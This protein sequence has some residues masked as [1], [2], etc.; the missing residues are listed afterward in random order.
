M[1]AIQARTVWW[2]GWDNSPS[3]QILVD[4][5][6]PIAEMRY[7]FVRRGPETHGLYWAE[8]DGF[9]SFFVYYGPGRGF[10]GCEFTLVTDNGATVVLKGPWSGNCANANRH[11]PHS[12]PVSL[13]DSLRSWNGQ[14]CF[15]G[16][17]TLV[18]FAAGVVDDFCPWAEIVPAA[19]PV[20]YRV[21]CRD[22]RDRPSMQ[23]IAKWGDLP[24]MSSTF[25]DAYEEYGIET[26]EEMHALRRTSPGEIKGR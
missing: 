15:L 20:T 13:T 5:I 22:G 23:E 11:F 24:N 18:S 7:Q 6:P 10:G 21:R 26:V 16:A 19:N 14:G 8:K 25:C 3:L 4:R 2:I 12:M 17:R 9:V 1:K